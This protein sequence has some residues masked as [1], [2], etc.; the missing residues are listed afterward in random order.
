MKALILFFF[1]LVGSALPP[2]VLAN[3]AAKQLITSCQ[4]LRGI[5]AKRDQ[6]RLLA[7]VTTSHAEAMRA[8]YCRGVLDEFRRT[9]NFCAQ[10]DWYKQA[11]RIASYAAYAD[12]L[13]S[14]DSLLRQSCEI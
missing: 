9:S 11:E 5:Y 7:G 13:P 8:G 2:V 14:V 1:L 3:E 4:E 12:Q 6:Q 10:S